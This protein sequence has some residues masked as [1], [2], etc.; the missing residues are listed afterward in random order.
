MILATSN[1]YALIRCE[2]SVFA[3]RRVLLF[4]GVAKALAKAAKRTA[5]NRGISLG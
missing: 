5:W 4:W 2:N 1:R 3:I